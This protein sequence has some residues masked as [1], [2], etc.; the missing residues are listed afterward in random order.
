[1]AEDSHTDQPEEPG[2]ETDLAQRSLVSRS[3]EIDATADDV[4]DAIADPERRSAWLDD[5]DALARVSRIDRVEPG[6]YLSWTWWHPDDVEAATQVRVTLNELATGATR[7]T[8]TERRP[9]L[10]SR[11]GSFTAQAS[12]ATTVGA[13]PAGTTTPA[14]PWDYR[15]LGLE[16]LFAVSCVRI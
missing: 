10:V 6:R 16:L 2:A 7:V 5:E 15:L 1:M 12:A 14:H 13:A 4:W 3:V 11:T 8:V 9:D